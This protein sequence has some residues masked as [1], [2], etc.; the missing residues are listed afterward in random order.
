MGNELMTQGVE[1]LIAGLVAG[2]ETT[3]EIR[4][5]EPRS[6]GTGIPV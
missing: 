4:G 2:I 5:G 1:E 3:P 6:A